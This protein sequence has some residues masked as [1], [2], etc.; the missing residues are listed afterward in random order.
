MNNIGKIAVIIIGIVFIFLTSKLSGWKKFLSWVLAILLVISQAYLLYKEVISEHMSAKSGKIKAVSLS[1]ANL[2]LYYGTNL[3]VTS[4]SSLT[5]EV[6]SHFISPWPKMDSYIRKENGKLLVDIIVRG[7]DTA[8]LAKLKNNEWIVSN[9]IFDRNFDDTKLEV[10]DKYENVP[11]LQIML[12]EDVV[13][14]NGVFYGENGMKHVATTKGLI[15]NPTKPLENLIVPWFKY[16]SSEHPG[17]S[18]K[19]S[20]QQSTSNLTDLLNRLKNRIN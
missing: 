6:L 18:I 16:P 13:I 17:E 14:L 11:I 15:I 8:I 19:E 9:D 4:A 3:F 1:N 10:F 12:F 7:Q 5:D 2:K 20:V